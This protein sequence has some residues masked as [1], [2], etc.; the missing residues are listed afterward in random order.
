MHDKTEEEPGKILHEMRFGGAGGLALGGGDIYY[1]SI[2][3]TPL[4]VMLMG[5]VRRWGAPKE[6]TD[7]LLPHADRALEWIER[8]G[9]RD[10]DGYVEYLKQSPDGLSNQGWKDSWDGIRYADGR[11]AEAPIALCEVQGYVYTGCISRAHFAQEAGDFATCQ[12]YRS[13]AAEL[14][15]RFHA[16]FLDARPRNL[17]P[18]FGR[19][20][21]TRSMRWRPTWGTVFGRG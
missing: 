19:G 3:S 20:Q 8:F 6:E 13:K 17:R 15:R 12:R 2:D 21:E 14:R 4:F 9:D 10:G 7:R 16:G 5:E 11:P 18:R 1:G